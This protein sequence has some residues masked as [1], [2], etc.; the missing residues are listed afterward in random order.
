M[1]AQE[2]E[3]DT[4]LEGSSVIPPN[5]LSSLRRKSMNVQNSLLENNDEEE[6]L[7]L[8]R[9][10]TTSNIT[11]VTK[12][13]KR[14]SLGLGFL[15]QLSAPEMKNRIYE[16]IKLNSEN[17]INLKNAFS[18]EIIDFM[19]YMI[20]KEDV[21]MSNLQVASTSLDVSTKIYGYRVDSVHTEILKMVGGLDTEVEATTDDLSKDTNNVQINNVNDSSKTK[22]AKRKKTKH[23]IFSV[24]D[25]LKGNAEILKPSLWLME[26]DN[27]QTANTLYQAMLPNHANSKFYLHEYNDIIVDT[28]ESETNM[29][30]L[31][32][33]IL[34]IEE[35]FELKICPPLTSFDFHGWTNEEKTDK[36]IKDTQPEENKENR[37]QFNLDASLPSGDEMAHVDDHY[38]DVPDTEE[39][40]VDKCV[41]IEKPVEKVVDLRQLVIHTGLTK[42]SEYSFLQKNSNIHW[43]GPSHWKINSFKKL[44]GESKIIEK[45]HQEQGTKKKEFVIHYDEN[46]KKAV[47]RKFSPGLASRLEVKSA[48]IEWQ[49]ET[50]TL[51]RDMHYNIASAFKLYLHKHIYL[52][53]KNKDLLD[54]THISDIED[55]NY[56][57]A[58][59]TLDYCPN[60][61]NED[62]RINEE[63]GEP[64]T[65]MM[66]TGDN[67][68]AMPKLT[69]KNT[70]VYSLREKR[71]DMRQLKKCIWK[72]LITNNN[73]TH[74]N[75]ESTEVQQEPLD[76]MKDSK[77]FSEIYGML[78]G[79][80]TETNAET[81]SFPIPFVS[82]LHLA[83]EKQLE[84]KSFSDLSDI[85]ILPN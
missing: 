71:I 70:I 28:V 51:P 78:T 58:N 3:M 29:K 75:T 64:E 46:T 34:H 35:F 76:K 44:Y 33:D 8:H 37:F 25:N 79:M 68:V 1:A 45:C 17:K 7:A 26:N 84:L 49:E 13:I 69:N 9:E 4:L 22:K 62:Y 60:I 72:A 61:P 23:N 10:M 77:N 63:N 74:V 18:L 55:Y 27:S 82:L 73:N 31:E 56:G 50:L 32:I 57:N 66:F 54:V 11:N 30:N 16:C 67:L 24:V 40:M 38:F 85:T 21:N 59:D 80:L 47:L 5:T 12:N 81:L 43:A 48:M 6:R 52:S 41:A 53:T 83:N 36:E 39:D 20:K 42:T 65:Q 19:T 2:D 15:A 14:Q